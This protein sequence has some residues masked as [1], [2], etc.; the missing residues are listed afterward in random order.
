MKKS[1]AAFC[2]CSYLLLGGCGLLSR[3][4]RFSSDLENKGIVAVSEKDAYLTSS[5]LLAEERKRSKLLDNFLKEQGIP[6]ALQVTKEKGKEKIFLYYSEKK[7][8]F[9]LERGPRDW[10]IIGPLQMDRK[11]TETVGRANV[12]SVGQKAEKKK[13]DQK[14]SST[15]SSAKK[16]DLIYEVKSENE[17]FVAIVSWY[18]GTAKNTGT[19]ARIN[20]ITDLTK[21]S[22]G[23][24]IR[25]PGYLITND[26]PLVTTR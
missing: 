20:D 24:R 6:S 10:I 1:F 8:F 7:E 23:Q 21:L 26:K 18:T 13:S 25:I 12:G 2:L 17:S 15:K 14:R 5:L 3:Q 9:E 16:R 4:S 19:I 22:P 11:I